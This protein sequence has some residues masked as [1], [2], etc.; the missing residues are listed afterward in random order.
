MGIQAYANPPMAGM[1]A[2]R[3][4]PQEDVQANHGYNIGLI[5]TNCYIL[6]FDHREGEL[7]TL[8]DSL[9]MTNTQI[10]I[11]S[12]LMNKLTHAKQDDKKADLNN[13][14]IAKKCAYLIHLRNSTIFADKIQGMP[15]GSPP[16]SPN[17]LNQKLQ[18]II[19]QIREEGAAE[20][21]INLVAILDKIDVS[22]IN[23]D[24]LSED[25]IDVVIQGMDAETKMLT[26][27][28]NECMM[29][30]NNKYED[31]SKMTENA[32]KVLDEV[33]KHIDSIIRKFTNR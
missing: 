4:F 16:S 17:L 12:D 11:I 30:I 29:K 14:E 13:D 22:S 10:K 31:R 3:A 21:D 28:L 23:I 18:E 7:N 8:I 27:D 9:Q 6:Y 5:L 32:H 1:Q 15:A 20:S 24:V 2:Y 33:S 19:D 25:Q 26:A